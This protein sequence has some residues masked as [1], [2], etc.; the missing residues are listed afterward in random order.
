[1]RKKYILLIILLISFFVFFHNIDSIR[2]MLGKY[3]PTKTKVLIKELFFGKETTFMVYYYNNPVNMLEKIW[4]GKFW[5]FL[6]KFSDI[7]NIFK[8]KI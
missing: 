7:V 4:F 5:L 3:F 6:A 8:K 2:F 1:M